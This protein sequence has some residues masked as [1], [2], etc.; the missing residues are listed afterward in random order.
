MPHEWQQG[1]CELIAGH[2]VH[3]ILGHA[4]LG[5]GRAFDEH[6]GRIDHLTLDARSAGL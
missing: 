3:Q 5:T 2:V 1:I 6:M 4:R